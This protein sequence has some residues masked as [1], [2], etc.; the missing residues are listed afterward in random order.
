MHISQGLHSYFES[1]SKLQNALI[2]PSNSEVCV[3]TKFGRSVTLFKSVGIKLCPSHYCLPPPWIQK[4]TYTSI[5]F[6]F[7]D[8]KLR[9]NFTIGGVNHFKNFTDASCI[10]TEKF[11][12]NRE[13]FYGWFGMGGSIM[14]WHPELQIGFAF[15]PTYFNLTELVSE[16]GA[17]L[18]QIVKDCITEN[19]M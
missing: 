12:K 9:T 1:T 4:A 19:S 5:I 14:Q 3:A 18:Q 2:A 15:I 13:G 11:N 6:F 17:V 8:G 10:E 7:A 16:R